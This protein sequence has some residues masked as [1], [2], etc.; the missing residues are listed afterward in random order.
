L[1][2]FFFKNFS[3]HLPVLAR[4]SISLTP[5]LL[6]DINKTMNKSIVGKLTYK[7]LKLNLNFTEAIDEIDLKI[8]FPVKIKLQAYSF[9]NKYPSETNQITVEV[10]LK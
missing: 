2:E 6:N 8:K 7:K 4:F 3:D 10:F 1:R 5:P 9:L